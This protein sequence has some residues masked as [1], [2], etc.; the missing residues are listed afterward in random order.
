MRSRMGTGQIITF[1]VEAKAVGADPIASVTHA[2]GKSPTQASKDVV[3][4]RALTCADT[5][6]TITE[7]TEVAGADVTA[8]PAHAVEESHTQTSWHSEMM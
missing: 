5:V 7:A 3:K 8:I 4:L 2:V 6:M 1:Y